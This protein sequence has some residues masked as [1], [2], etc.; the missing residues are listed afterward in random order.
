MQSNIE[1]SHWH[2]Q[3]TSEDDIDRDPSKRHQFKKFEKRVLNTKI[4][5]LHRTQN[6]KSQKSSN[7]QT[8]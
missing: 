4:F 6:D 8:V 2:L 1:S 7:K 3:A 5:K